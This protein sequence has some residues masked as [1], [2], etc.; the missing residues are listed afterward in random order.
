MNEARIAIPSSHPG[1]LAAEIYPWLLHI[2]EE[3]LVLTK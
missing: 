2:D 1:G 3:L